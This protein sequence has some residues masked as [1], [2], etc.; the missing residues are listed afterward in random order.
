M[1]CK[2]YIPSPPNNP[3]GC[4]NVTFRLCKSKQKRVFSVTFSLVRKSNQKVPQRSADLW[5]PGERFKI[6][7]GG[8]I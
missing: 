2:G 6:P 7:S 5:T 1:F 8:A 4:F 3:Q